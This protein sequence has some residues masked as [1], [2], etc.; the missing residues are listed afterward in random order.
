MPTSFDFARAPGHLIRRAQQI[1]V[2]EFTHAL[3]DLDITPVQFALLNA[4]ID[5]PG[6]DQVTLAKTA[7]F[8]PATSGSVIARLEA[9][10]WLRREA[11]ALDRRRKLLFVT[12]EG[13]LAVEQMSATVSQ[14]Q[15]NILAPLT[16]KDQALFMALLHQLVSGH[17]SPAD[18]CAPS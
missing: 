8:D 7:A 10:R 2:A 11:D 15:Q 1:A 16:A 12:P 13:A 14:V 9:K 17:E 3:A 5:A 6:M 18:P 4:V